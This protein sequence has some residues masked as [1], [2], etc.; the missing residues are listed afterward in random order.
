VISVTPA[1]NATAVPDNTVITLVFD[2]PIDPLTF[3]SSYGQVKLTLQSTGVTVPTTVTF[4]TD[5]KTAFLTPSASLTS[6]TTYNIIA[7]YNYVTDQAGNFLNVGV[8]QG[9]T[10]Q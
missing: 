10:A 9:F 2:S 1:A 4:S 5:F 8:N 3:D 6:G 7:N